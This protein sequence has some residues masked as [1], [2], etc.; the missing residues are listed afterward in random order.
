M[1]I[2]LK[3]YLRT[4]TLNDAQKSAEWFNDPALRKFL[5]MQK[6][7][8]IKERR[9]FLEKRLKDPQEKIFSI[10]LKKKHIY[11]GNIY[12]YKIDNQKKE[13]ELG[14]FIGE[15]K[16][17]HKG[18]AS[19]ALDLIEKHAFS[20]LNLNRLYLKTL[21]FN[22]IASHFFIKNNYRLISKTEDL[23]IFEKMQFYS[24]EINC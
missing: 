10:I 12:L 19:E 6:Q 16:Y 13:A 5:G 14:L 15:K 20:E 18:Y 24:D 8:S 7:Q 2:G 22:Q 4:T 17:Q 9:L 21:N 23:L 3:I 1:L 11:L